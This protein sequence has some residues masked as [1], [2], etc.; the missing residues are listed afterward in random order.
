MME[1]N[2]MDGAMMRLNSRLALLA[3]TFWNDLS[4]EYN[5]ESNADG[6]NQNNYDSCSIRPIYGPC[7]KG[8]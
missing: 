3:Y 4:E 2:E 8:R 1:K 6:L 5:G 7:H